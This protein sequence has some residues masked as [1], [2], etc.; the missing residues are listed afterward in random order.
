MKKGTFLLHLILLIYL[1]LICVAMFFAAEAYGDSRQERSGCVSGVHTVHGPKVSNALLNRGCTRID[2]LHYL[3][4]GTEY[5]VEAECPNFQ[6]RVKQYVIGCTWKGRCY[7]RCDILHEA[8][9]F[10]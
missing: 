8:W 2:T 9:K 6:G 10:D 4:D 3:R 5:V 1:G 7:R